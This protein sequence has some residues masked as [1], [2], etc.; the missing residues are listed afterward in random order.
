MAAARENATYSGVKTD[1]T[2]SPQSDLHR[3][4]C[5]SQLGGCAIWSETGM[6]GILHFGISQ[7]EPS[8]KVFRRQLCDEAST[9]AAPFTGHAVCL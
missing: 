3:P 7:L 5:Q 2:I 8:K 9:E 6:L 4:P 1:G